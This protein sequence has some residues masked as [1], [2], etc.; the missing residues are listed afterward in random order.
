[1]N[2]HSY[3]ITYKYSHID[4]LHTCLEANESSNR[5]K[6]TDK[7]ANEDGRRTVQE[8]GKISRQKYVQDL[9][10]PS[11]IGSIRE[12]L[13][14]NAVD[15]TN[16]S[17]QL[18]S[19][20]SS[21]MPLPRGDDSGPDLARRLRRALVGPEG[22][23]K[24]LPLDE[25]H[26]IVS[27]PMVQRELQKLQLG[28][29]A[30]MIVPQSP[31]EA[32]SKSRQKI[33][34]I[35]ALLDQSM[36]RFIKSFIEEDIHDG[37]LP[38]EF[39]VGEHECMQRKRNGELEDIKF[40][41]DHT[42]WKSHLS[43]SFCRYQW[44]LLVPYL[45]LS[46]SPESAVRDYSL[47]SEEILP[48]IGSDGSRFGHG[49]GGH[50]TVWKV[51]FHKAHISSKSRESF[52]VK[53]LHRRGQ[54]N[55]EKEAGPLRRLG[56]HDHPHLVRLLLTYSHQ[57]N[58]YLLFPWA[59]GGNLLDL[60][61]RYQSTPVIKG[62]RVI[63]GRWMAKQILGICEGLNKIHNCKYDGPVQLL[64]GYGD[65]NKIF[66][67]H[68]DIKPA[69]IL[70]FEQ[71]MKANGENILG[72]LK[73]SDFGLTIFHGDQSRSVDNPRNTGCT[74][75]YRA[76]EYDINNRLSQSYDVWT[77]GCVL[78]EFVTWYILGYEGIEDFIQIRMNEECNVGYVLDEEFPRNGFF[79]AD[80]PGPGRVKYVWKKKS[81]FEHFNYLRQHDRCTDLAYDLLDLIQNGLLRV[82]YRKRSSINDILKRL[83][84]INAKC[85]NDDYCSKMSI[86]ALVR[87]KTDLS[88][89]GADQIEQIEKSKH[90]HAKPPLKRHKS[91]LCQVQS[92][93]EES[94]EMTPDEIPRRSQMPTRQMSLTITTDSHNDTRHTATR[95]EPQPSADKNGLEE[96][97]HRELSTDN[98]RKRVMTDPLPQNDRGT[99]T[100]VPGTG[101]RNVHRGNTSEIE[102]RDWT[103]MN[104]GERNHNLAG[105]EAKQLVG[106][107]PRWSKI[108][109][110]LWWL[111]SKL[112]SKLF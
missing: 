97:I 32:G 57:S 21:L 109:T 89:L 53:E 25:L 111:C 112:V 38:F 107:L 68:G 40:C 67:R 9:R 110:F 16:T 47:R 37:D 79:V 93:P 19:P 62:N 54:T 5:D 22:S 10:P 102:T 46:T 104:R 61:M 31:E 11:P 98:G 99:A 63:V 43:D 55:L 73:L 23:V 81:V 108:G 77:L 14:N 26:K 76:P 103:N 87:I 85:V 33:L 49:S 74:Y 82:D 83:G 7:L 60:W 41:K 28:E 29:Y 1:M 52:A 106:H 58:F 86:R 4:L 35:L 64:Q 65:K 12:T 70:C 8:F 84:D 24:F 20:K 18:V 101:W 3:G 39:Q 15:G 17:S 2:G 91:T 36:L 92:I 94:V 80:P 59:N 78:L 42:E 13:T 34:A 71:D 56:R 44:R 100:E 69:N 50:G 30:Q 75:T 90:V 95:E 72:V 105:E 45:E 88:E 6:M 96:F 27:F 51:E 48:I 66:G